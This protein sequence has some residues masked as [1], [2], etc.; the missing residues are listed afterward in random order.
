MQTNGYQRDYG[1]KSTIV[2]FW[3]IMMA[4]VAAPAITIARTKPGAI[5]PLAGMLTCGVIAPPLL[6]YLSWNYWPEFQK[7][8]Q[9]MPSDLRKAWFKVSF[10]YI[11]F[12]M[13]QAMFA[14]TLVGHCR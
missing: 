2:M 11:L 1:A 5:W 14:Y 10:G 13:L 12:G 4:M 7:F 6:G 8:R 9:F 3:L